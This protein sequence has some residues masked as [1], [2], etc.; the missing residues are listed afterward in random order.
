MSNAARHA[1]AS[2]I[3]KIDIKDFFES[4]S[5]RQVFH[6][7]RRLGY[8][9]LLAFE[10]A[11]LST[12]FY[13]SSQN[14]HISLRQTRW[15]WT[16]TKLGTPYE[17][18]AEVGHL[19]QGAP[20]SPLLANLVVRDMDSSIA[21]L[22]RTA[23]AVYTR[24]AD[25]MVLSLSEGSRAEATL[26]LQSVAEVVTNSGFR[27]N[28]KKTHVR[29]PGAR[30]VVTGLTVNDVRP[31]LPR[32]LKDEVELALYHIKKHGLI[33]H[34]ERMNSRDPFGY[35]SHLKGL[36]FY[37]A[38]VDPAYAAKA[39][40]TLQQVLQPYAELLDMFRTFRP[41]AAANKFMFD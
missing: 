13:D 31:R 26:L 35:L 8:P 9:A 3:V 4:I 11:R 10:L 27:V 17:R 34:M 18:V 37:A 39:L 7:F 30:K 2:W 24:Y 41:T 19:P 16:M 28:R 29:G 33:G 14:N 20:T 21:A 36:L 1:G 25:D 40:S 22:A 5:E 23:G 38:Q 32:G 15:R 12:R 6:V